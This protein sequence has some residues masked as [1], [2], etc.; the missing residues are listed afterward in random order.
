M[1]TKAQDYRVRAEHCEA[2]ARRAATAATEQQLRELA[3]CWRAMAEHADRRAARQRAEATKLRTS[4][5]AVR[6]GTGTR[7]S[8]SGPARAADIGG[9]IFTA[10][11]TGT[12]FS[13][14]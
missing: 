1:R 7:T 12:T 2:A 4:A 3:R 14:T 11:A 5:Q 10:P 13:L 9:F 6:S 8:Y